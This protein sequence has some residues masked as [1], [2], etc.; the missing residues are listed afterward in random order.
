MRELNNL[1]GKLFRIDSTPQ[2]K[3]SFL[4]II[5]RALPGRKLCPAGFRSGLALL[6]EVQ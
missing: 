2:E 3:P 6:S 5:G 4:L 1:R